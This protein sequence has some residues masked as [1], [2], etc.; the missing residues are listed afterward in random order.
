MYRARAANSASGLSACKRQT[1][2]RLLE[3][4]VAFGVGNPVVDEEHARPEQSVFAGQL[5]SLPVKART[6]RRRGRA[7]VRR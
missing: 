7:P 2:I 4:V 1:E 3:P 6:R 5:P